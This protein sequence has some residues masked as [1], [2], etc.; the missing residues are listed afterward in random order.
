VTVDAQ[1]SRSGR[2]W[3][4]SSKPPARRNS[5]IADLASAPQVEVRAELQGEPV[6]HRAFVEA[7]LVEYGAAWLDPAHFT[8]RAGSQ[9]EEWGQRKHRA[10][11]QVGAHAEPRFERRVGKLQLRPIFPGCP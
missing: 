8:E 9:R 10:Q 2:T 5:A 3:N 1:L 11:A 6:V 4:G 7:R